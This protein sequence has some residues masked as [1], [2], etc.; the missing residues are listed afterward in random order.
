MQKK[1]FYYKK[2]NN[3]KI[4]YFIFIFLIILS[5]F[6]IITQPKDYFIV[7]ENNKIFYVKP[8]DSEGERVQYLDKKSI[9]NLNITN[10]SEY[11]D[12]IPLLNYTIQIYSDSNLENV[13]IFLNKFL[14]SRSEIIDLRE[15]YTFLIETELSNI[16]FLSYK[17][18][19]NHKTA[20]D[21]CKKLSF[22]DKCV[23]LNLNNQ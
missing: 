22:I 23:I 1:I 5:I 3:F 9:N 21:Y 17:S 7:Y 13:E 8:K 20:F 6:F 19:N 10:K 18:F 2:K 14:K 15:I 4:I 12:N 16:Y 11:F